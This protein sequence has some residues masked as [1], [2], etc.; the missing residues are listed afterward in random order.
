MRCPNCGAE[1]PEGS[2]F[3]HNCGTTVDAQA[4]S[5]APQPPVRRRPLLLAAG[6]GVF[7]IVASGLRCAGSSTPTN[8]LQTRRRPAMR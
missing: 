5:E 6:A 1:F 8:P 3:C 7:A 4:P 2:A